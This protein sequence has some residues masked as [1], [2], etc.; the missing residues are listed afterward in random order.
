MAENKKQILMI[1]GVK[2]MEIDCLYVD[3]DPNIPQIAGI[4]GGFYYLNGKKVVDPEHLA[5][6]KPKVID[7]ER[8]VQP[9]GVRCPDCGMGFTDKRALNGHKNTHRRAAVKKEAVGASA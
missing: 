7:Q 6:T 4:N 9:G 5:I 1:D 3:A 8:A 2:K